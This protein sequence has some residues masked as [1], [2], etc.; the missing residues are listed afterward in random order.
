MGAGNTVI[1]GQRLKW[2]SADW[3]VLLKQNTLASKGGKLQAAGL[4]AQVVK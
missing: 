3:A 2:V 4:Q 1:V